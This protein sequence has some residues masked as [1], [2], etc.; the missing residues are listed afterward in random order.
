MGLPP[1]RF[2]LTGHNLAQI[3]NKSSGKKGPYQ[4]FTGK[5]TIQGEGLFKKNIFDLR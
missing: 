2:N 3:V 1:N 5:E 4:C